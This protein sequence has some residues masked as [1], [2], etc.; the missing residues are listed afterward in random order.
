MR[1]RLP[2]LLR[3]AERAGTRLSD[4]IEISAPIEDVVAMF[5]IGLFLSWESK[6]A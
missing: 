1:S 3:N 5:L 4:I 2:A 6:P